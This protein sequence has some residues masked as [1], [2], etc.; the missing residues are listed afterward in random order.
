MP[1]DAV[2]RTTQKSPTDDAV[3]V[4]HAELPEDERE[5]ARTAV[6]EPFY[7][8]CPELPEALRSFASRFQKINDTYLEYRETTY[9]VWIRIEDTIRAGTASAPEENPS[10][11]FI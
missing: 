8:A 1:Q 2:V 11:G 5:I 9:G 10:C 4:S 3:V 6:E 7:H